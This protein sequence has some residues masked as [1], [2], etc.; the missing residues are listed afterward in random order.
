MG[1][2][3]GL[4]LVAGRVTQQRWSR[5]YDETV[6]LLDAWPVP[7]LGIQR[8]VIAGS[9]V[10]VYT[11]DYSNPNNPTLGWRVVGDAHS[12]LRGENFDFPSELPR[13]FLE[14]AEG[15]ETADALVSEAR[16]EPVLSVFHRKTQGQPYHQLIV[17]VATL[18]E[19]RL[20]QS[21]L[22]VG[23]IDERDGRSAAAQLETIFGEPFAPPVITRPKQLVERLRSELGESA[24]ETAERMCPPRHSALLADFL[25]VLEQSSRVRNDLEHAVSCTDVGNL[26]EEARDLILR[27][28]RQL[29][30]KYGNP[31]TKGEHSREE[32]LRLIAQGLGR[33]YVL[34]EL[35]WDDLLAADDAELRFLAACAPLRGDIT[36]HQLA[37]ALFESRAVRELAMTSWRKEH[38]DV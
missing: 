29:G 28:P 14:K 37:L 19:N 24:P 11:R 2:Y 15:P 34:T 6:T 33:S 7:P 30:E 16:Q 22:A 1:V 25:S 10:A 18:V 35:A 32:L 3:V 21:A 27:F 12:R 23:D 4:R 31:Y 20:P 9:E 36:T 5:I 8:R 38:Q 26:S 17:A 13:H